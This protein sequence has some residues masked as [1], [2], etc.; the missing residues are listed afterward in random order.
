[1]DIDFTQITEDAVRDYVR[2]SLR[3]IREN[4]MRLSYYELQITFYEYILVKHQQLQRHL[5]EH[6]DTMQVTPSTRDQ[7]RPYLFGRLLHEKETDFIKQKLENIRGDSRR[8]KETNIYL[9]TAETDLIL[10]LRDIKKKYPYL[11]SRVMEEF[12]NT[13]VFEGGM[14]HWLNALNY[15]LS[16]DKTPNDNFI[17]GALWEK[18]STV[19]KCKEIYENSLVDVFEHRETKAKFLF[20]GPKDNQ[21]YIHLL[22]TPPDGSPDIELEAPLILERGSNLVDFQSFVNLFGLFTKLVLAETPEEFRKLVS[23][24]VN[25]YFI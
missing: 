13:K 18:S 19:D 2:I 15:A 7:L 24:H 23:N 16:S 25:D 9:G 22:L 17:Q 3:D 5:N 1:M 11:Y 14:Y 6:L 4:T 20:L 21:G 10:F 12:R 8:Y